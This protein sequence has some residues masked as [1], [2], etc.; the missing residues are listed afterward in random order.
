MRRQTQAACLL[1]APRRTIFF[2][3]FFIQMSFFIFSV[4]TFVFLS[5]ICAHFFHAPCASLALAGGIPG[6]VIWLSFSVNHIARD[7]QPA[8]VQ[9]LQHVGHNSADFSLQACGGEGDG[10][11]A[12]A[13]GVTAQ[14]SVGGNR[15]IRSWAWQRDRTWLAPWTVQWKPVFTVAKFRFSQA[16]AQLAGSKC[17]IITAFKSV[18]I[19]LHAQQFCGFLSEMR[20]R[21]SLKI[22]RRRR[23]HLQSLI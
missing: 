16:H 23:I 22:R 5:G 7:F 4:S 19:K 8:G 6:R 15:W 2:F 12:A 18:L 3:F 10:A 20:L 17:K 13:A 21:P 11:T 9:N 14:T 1:S